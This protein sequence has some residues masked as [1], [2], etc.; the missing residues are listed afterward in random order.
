[1]TASELLRLSCEV[2]PFSQSATPVPTFCQGYRLA[3][4]REIVLARAAPSL[5]TPSQ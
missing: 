1:M 4:I 2:L 5:L 3:L